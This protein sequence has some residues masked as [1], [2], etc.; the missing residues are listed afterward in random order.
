MCDQ[1]L[2]H[3]S[4]QVY[5]RLLLKELTRSEESKHWKLDGNPEKTGKAQGIDMERMTGKDPM[6]ARREA[7]TERQGGNNASREREA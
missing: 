3:F 1:S 5:D 2:G 6:R 4:D 7:S